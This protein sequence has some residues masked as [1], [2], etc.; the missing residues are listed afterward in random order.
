MILNAT[1][2][3][4]EGD[5]RCE[6]FDATDKKID[7][8]IALKLHSKHTVFVQSM[9]IFNS[10]FVNVCKSELTFVYMR[11]VFSSN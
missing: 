5:Y 6:G 2:P 8:T 11:F 9:R 3:D 1:K 7:S 10:V 4:D